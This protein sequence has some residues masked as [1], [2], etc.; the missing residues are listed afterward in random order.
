MPSVLLTP[1][2]VE[3]L[4]LAEAKSYLRVDTVDEDD[5]IAALIAAARLL[6]EAYARRALI[7]QSWRLSLDC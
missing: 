5:T 6:V 7:T 3:P 1:P 2:A 4:T